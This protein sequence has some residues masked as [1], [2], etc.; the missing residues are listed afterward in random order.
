MKITHIQKIIILMT[1][2]LL[3]FPAHAISGRS[4]SKKKGGP[5]SHAPAHGYRAK[6]KYNYYP[7]ANVYFDS[8]RNLYFYVEGD[9]WQASVS[10]PLTL[11]AQL[12][13]YISVEME[14]DKP[15]LK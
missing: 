11:K 2:I 7:E 9:S 1:C 4:K 3:L 15:Y 8:S 14:Y 12:G 13:K 10:L 6:Y 5:P